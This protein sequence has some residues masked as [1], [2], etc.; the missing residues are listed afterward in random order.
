[1]QR[2]TEILLY[3]EQLYSYLGI[4]PATTVKVSIKHGGLKD[5]QL[6]AVRSFWSRRRLVCI[7]SETEKSIQV[8][9]SSIQ[10]G[11]V[12]LVKEFTQPLFLLFDF[13]EFEDSL[14]EDIVTSYARGKVP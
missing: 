6:S 1:M 9:L 3:C 4:D 11:L 5:R 13:Q 10:P 8:E 12:S 14:Y 2:V 7:D